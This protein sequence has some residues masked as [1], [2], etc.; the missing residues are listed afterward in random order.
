MVIS[1][2]PDLVGQ[3]QLS[4][5]I[6]AQRRHTCVFG[7]MIAPVGLL[8]DTSGS[9]SFLMNVHGLRSPGRRVCA[10]AV[11]SINAGS[12]LGPPTSGPKPG[13]PLDKNK[14]NDQPKKQEQQNQPEAE[15]GGARIA[16][17]DRPKA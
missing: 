8:R 13:S 7:R 14:W 16:F 5:R 6:A 9:R 1:A 10:R 11:A 4:G 12:C 17:K 15:K 3:H 2:P